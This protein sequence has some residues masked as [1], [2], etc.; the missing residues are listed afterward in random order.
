MKIKSMLLIMLALTLVLSCSSKKSEKEENAEIEA[1]REIGRKQWAEDY[2]GDENYKPKPEEALA[3]SK[4]AI[5]YSNLKG[6]LNAEMRFLAENGR[7]TDNKAELGFIPRDEKYS[8]SISMTPSN[9]FKITAIGN[10]DNDDHRDV[11]E[12]NHLGD[13]E[14]IEDDLRNWK[15]TDGLRKPARHT[16]KARD[17]EKKLKVG[18]ERRMEELQEDQ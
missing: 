16:Q 12:M 15:N 3:A 6:I 14:K 18:M 13:I 8:Y 4:R 7:Y 2:Y 10:I 5:A 17:V 11:L 9:N 1:Q